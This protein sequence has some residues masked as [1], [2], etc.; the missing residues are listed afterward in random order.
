LIIGPCQ[1]PLAVYKAL[2]RILE[3]AG[4]ADAANK[5]VYSDIPLRQ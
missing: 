4:V 2:V 5:V 3:E 1:H